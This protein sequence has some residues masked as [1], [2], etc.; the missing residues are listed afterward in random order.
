MLP[1]SVD[2]STKTS[3]WKKERVTGN[4]QNR[5][6]CQHEDVWIELGMSMYIERNSH[7][8]LKYKST[9]IKRNSFVWIGVVNQ[10]ITMIQQLLL[11]SNSPINSGNVCGFNPSNKNEFIIKIE[12][13]LLFYFF[14]FGD[15]FLSNSNASHT[16]YHSACPALLQGTRGRGRS[17]IKKMEGISHKH[18]VKSCGVIENFVQSE[19]RQMDRWDKALRLLLDD[20][21]Y[22]LPCLK[23]K[24]TNINTR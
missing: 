12:E 10:D 18:H 7:K 15:L 22:W 13:T 11:N 1:P 19:H 3:L 5:S 24:S 9:Y 14:L 6:I 4:V 16:Q 8:W 17:T 23:M 2:K 20:N 21:E